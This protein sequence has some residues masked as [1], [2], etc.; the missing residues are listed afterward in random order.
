MLKLSVIIF[1]ALAL[2]ACG[3]GSESGTANV[4]VTGT[5]S[6]PVISATVTTLNGPT[7]TISVG[8]QDFLIM[9]NGPVDLTINGSSDNVWIAPGQPTGTVKI[10]GDGNNLIFLPGASVANFL[11]TG[12][13][14]TIWVPVG[15]SLFANSLVSGTNTLKMY[16]P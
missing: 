4:T 13:N 16:T 6:A 14:N 2:A 8:A 3:G 1:S 9:F 5:L 10:A 15:P 12:L 11:L 7:F